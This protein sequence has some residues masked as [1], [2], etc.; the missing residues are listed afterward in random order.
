MGDTLQAV[1]FEP[2]LEQSLL[3]AL[4]AGD[5]GSFL[6]VDPQ[7]MEMLLEGI[8][9]ALTESERMG[10]RPV[11]LCSPQLRP[12][13]RRLCNR[14]S[15]LWGALNIVNG[16]MTIW[17]LTS[18]PVATTCIWLPASDTIWPNQRSR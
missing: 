12:A 6:A 11:V 15:L 5:S 18:Q 3:E 2:L 13:V 8:N 1:T 16:L 14:L 7:R 9:R 17:L 10:Q 4:R